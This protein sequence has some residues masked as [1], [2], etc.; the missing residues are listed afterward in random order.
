M[1]SYQ[2]SVVPLSGGFRFDIRLPS[3]RLIT[4]KTGYAEKIEQYAHAREAVG[5]GCPKP[6][7]GALKMFGGSSG[8]IFEIPNI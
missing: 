4:A 7:V 1:K 8:G 6:V 5:W 2:L 3:V